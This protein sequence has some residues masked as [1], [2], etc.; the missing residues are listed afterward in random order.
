MKIVWSSFHTV[1]SAAI[2]VPVTGLRF[3]GFGDFEN[4]QAVKTVESLV[5]EMT[6]VVRRGGVRS[7][8]IV[9]GI[10]ESFRSHFVASPTTQQRPGI[11]SSSE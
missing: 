3:T 10:D 1:C 8:P 6:A 7:R 2:E 9:S 5:G 11:V 4:S